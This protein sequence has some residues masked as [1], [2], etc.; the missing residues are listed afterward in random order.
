[1][2]NSNEKLVSGLVALFPIARDAFKNGHMN[3]QVGAIMSNGKVRQAGSQMTSQA[4][5][6]LRHSMS[7]TKLGRQLASRFAPK[8]SPL[9]AI[10]IALV[11]AGF[12]WTYLSKRQEL[13]RNKELPLPNGK[14]DIAKSG[15]TVDGNVMP[16]I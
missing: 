11:G 15:V 3:R 10:A 13:R 4:E 1:M 5:K 8:P 2:A 9:P 7:N 6:Y 12:V 16:N 14:T